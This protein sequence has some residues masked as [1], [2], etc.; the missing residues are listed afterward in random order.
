M[1]IGKASICKTVFSNIKPFISLALFIVAFPL[2]SYTQNIPVSGQVKDS[3]SKAGIELATI[4][5]INQKGKVE[6][7]ST[8]DNNGRFQLTA[9]TTGTYSIAIEFVGYKKKLISEV[10]VQKKTSLGVIVLQPYASALNDVV[11]TG[12][13]NSLK[14]KNDRQVFKASMFDNAKGGTAVDLIKNLPSV[15]VNADGEIT[16]RGSNNFLVLING[17]PSLVDAATILSQLPAGSIENIEII[18]TPSARFDPDGKAGI[19][20]IITKKGTDDGW[21]VIANTM[22]GLSAINNYNNGRNP[23]RMS[24]DITIGFKK[25]KW[26]LN[27]GFNYLRNDVSGYR[28]GNVYTTINDTLTK[29]PSTGERSFRR[30]NYGVRLAATFTIDKH[31]IISAGFYEGYKHQDREADLNY[32]NSKT[33]VST[34]QQ[35]SAN[36]Y[37]DANNQARNGTFTLFNIDYTHTFNNKSS[38]TASLLYEGADLNGGTTNNNLTSP[39]SNDTIQFTKTVYNNPLN[40][41]RVR[42]DYQK[43]IGIGT[44]ETGYQFRYDTQNGNFDYYLKDLGTN[45]FI[46]DPS[47]SSAVK[48]S[49]VIHAVY[50][51]YSV[52]QS[53]WYYSAGLRYETAERKLWFGN[54]PQPS[55]SLNNL[56][57]SAQLKYTASNKWKWKAGISK[58]VKRTTN[59]ELNPFPEREHSETLERGD[60]S[61]LPEFVTLA[62]I[63]TEN[64]FKKG[65]WYSTIY[66][67][68]TSNIIQRLNNIYNDTILN[69]IYTNATEGVQYGIETGLTLN[70]TKWWQ[71]MAGINVF[72]S[73]INGVVFNGTIAVKNSKI[74]YT[75][76]TTQTFKLPAKWTAQLSISY[77]SLRPTAQGEDGAYLS[78]SLSIK[79]TTNNNNWTFQVQWLNIDCGMGIS[80]IQRITTSGQGF[81]TTT[82]YIF[83]PDVIQLG[84]GYNFNKKNKKVKL[85]VSEIGEKEF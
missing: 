16:L 80:N 57:P 32:T 60:P 76:N 38:L 26:E 23:S 49:N 75:C 29:F 36:N 24:G 47:F 19:I 33:L 83:E 15:A 45:N 61:L 13:S 56:F 2:F 17:K 46:L 44:L 3:I 6:N 50:A 40:G 51:Q 21:L 12:Q 35:I 30:Y 81:Y 25:N 8:T 10:S 55:L 14:L 4:S 72:E 43:K 52:Q 27:G 42:L 62:E 79:K 64:N 63:G 82:N 78:P 53:K 54:I 5:I 85:P 68:H 7:I 69:R 84:I 20:N 74:A 31:N 59:T 34:G 48:V 66:Y 41:Y 11:I 70:P 58:R 37:Y 22:G 65:S 1:N 39:I 77:L 71:F 18:T 9:N 28:E 73:K 67:Q